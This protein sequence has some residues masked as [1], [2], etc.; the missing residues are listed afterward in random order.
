MTAR[1]TPVRTGPTAVIKL[2]VTNAFVLQVLTDPIVSTIL[3]NALAQ[4]AKTTVHVWI[5][6]MGFIVSAS[7]DSPG[8]PA[9]STSMNVFPTHVKIKPAAWIWLMAIAVTVAMALMDC[10][11]KTT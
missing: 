10:T 1:V 3:T 5:K 6:L 7:L 9:S 11:V 2:T 8:Q 4:I